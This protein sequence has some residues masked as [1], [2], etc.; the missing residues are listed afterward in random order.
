[1]QTIIRETLYDHFKNGVMK[2]PQS[3]CHFESLS[4]VRPRVMARVSS[5]KRNVPKSRSQMENK[6]VKLEFSSA[7]LME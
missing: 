1:M 2:N 7:R 5:L 6:L 4:E 3:R